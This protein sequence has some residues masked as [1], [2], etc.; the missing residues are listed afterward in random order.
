MP[1][2][3]EIAD[4]IAVVTLNNPPVNAVTLALYE[5]IGNLFEEV[6]GRSDVN[7]VVFTSAGER[8]FCAG[9]D[10]KEFLAAT[11]EEDPHRA[12]VVRKS[13]AQVRLCAVPV[14]GAINGPALGAGAVFASVCDIRIA[15]KRATFAMPEINVGRCGGGAHM[16]RHLPQGWLRRMFFT[17]QPIDAETAWRL[18]F[19][20]E[21]VEPAALTE[22]AMTMARTIAAKAPLGLR[23][24]KRS[25]NEIEDMPVEPGYEIEQG[26]STR[27]MATEDAREAT[28]AVVEKRA[29]VFKGR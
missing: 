1:I 9:L 22:T 17:G 28:R 2:E 20:Q 24:G 10:L 3:L 25:L 15:S 7:V 14:I 8:A 5:E 29:P 13:F 16:G 6:G 27:L 12:A 23:M 11:V 21:V 19:V 18:G 4:R 26:Y